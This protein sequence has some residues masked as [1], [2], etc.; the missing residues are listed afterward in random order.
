MPRL[1]EKPTVIV[2][3]GNVPKRI[4]EF[5][6]RASSG[7]FI[8]GNLDPALLLLPGAQLERAIHEYLGPYR[9]LPAQARQRWMCGLGHGVLPGTPEEA[10]RALVRIVRETFA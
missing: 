5:V 6:G 7:H 3:A 8:Q 1:I 2:A 9:A 10:I 4:E